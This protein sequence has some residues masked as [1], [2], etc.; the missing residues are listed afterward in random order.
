MDSFLKTV[1]SVWGAGLF[2]GLKFFV[3][4]HKFGSV[5]LSLQYLVKAVSSC[6]SSVLVLLHSL[7]KRKLSFKGEFLPLFAFSIGLPEEFNFQ[8][9]SQSSLCSNAESRL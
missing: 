3:V 4:S 6:F 5:S 9:R 8:T 1:Y 2:P 7:Y